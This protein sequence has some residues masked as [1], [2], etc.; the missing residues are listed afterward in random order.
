MQS[1]LDRIEAVRLFKERMT[2]DTY[3]MTPVK[4]SRQTAEPVKD[5]RL[6]KEAVEDSGDDSTTVTSS[7]DSYEL[8]STSVEVFD[9]S[10]DI[11]EEGFGPEYSDDSVTTT[12]GDDDA[13][14]YLNSMDDSWEN[15]ETHFLKKT[16]YFDISGPE[17][18]D[19]ILDA[20]LAQLDDDIGINGQTAWDKGHNS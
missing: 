13:R 5:R 14:S 1:I 6:T 19:D 15:S 3:R 18:S 2:A 8:P 16:E 9:M 12:C 20:L 17:Y 7:D 11:D 4:D 10:N